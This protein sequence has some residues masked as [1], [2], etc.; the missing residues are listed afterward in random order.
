MRRIFIPGLL[1]IAVLVLIV[2]CNT[3]AR[4]QNIAAQF[5]QGVCEEIDEANMAPFD[6]GDRVWFGGHG[7]GIVTG[8]DLEFGLMFIR[9]VGDPHAEAI[10]RAEAEVFW[11]QNFP[12]L[13]RPALQRLR[14]LK[15]S[16]PGDFCAGGPSLGSELGFPI[17]DRFPA[18]T[19]LRH[20]RLKR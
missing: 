16:Y 18:N 3:P 13:H 17:R 10:R 5:P 11:T 4:A 6:V 12:T 20:L 14:A 19:G 8:F 2:Y 15:A 1:F 9:P 7:K